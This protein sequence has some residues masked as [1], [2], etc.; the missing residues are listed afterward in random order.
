MCRIAGIVSKQSPE[1]AKQVVSSM[2][3][4]LQHGG[5]DD[6][7]VFQSGQVTLGHRRLSI[8]DLSPSGHQPM[9]YGQGDL[10]LSYNGEVYNYKELKAELVQ[11]GVTFKSSSD[12]EVILEAY[13]HW[14]VEAFGRFRGIF[15]FALL[16]LR[17]QKLLL[18]RDYPG[19]KPMY[20]WSV[21]D[22]ILFSSEVKAFCATAI[23][24]VEDIR[25]KQSFLAFGYLPHPITTIQGVT[26]L[27]PGCFLEIDIHTLESRRVSYLKPFAHRAFQSVEEGIHCVRESVEV[28]LKRNLVAD[29]PLGVFLSGGIDSSLLTL[30]C[31]KEIGESLVTVS[32]NFTDAAFDETPFQSRVIEKIGGRHHTSVTV[33]KGM[34]WKQMPAIWDAMDQ[35]T[36]DGVNSYFVSQAAHQAGLKAVLSGLGA[37][38]L[39]AGYQS[40]SR[41]QIIP[42]LRRLPAKRLAG[43]IARVVRHNWARLAYLTIEGPVGNALFL[44]GILTP[45]VIARIL[46]CDES[47][48]WNTLR[49]IPYERAPELDGAS[50]GMKLE[51]DFYMKNQLL[52]DTD[53]MSMR[54]ALEA[55]VPFLDA[56]V[57]SQAARLTP[58]YHQV[59]ADRPKYFLT[60]AFE[61]LLPAEIV[62]RKKQGFTFPFKPWLKEKIESDSSFLSQRSRQVLP[63]QSFREGRVH[64][65]QVWSGVVLEEFK[66]AR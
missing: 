63:V 49:G 31:A 55:R 11:L 22:E 7:G 16:D 38:E 50:E 14:G 13:R 34:L 42:M 52:K 32:V 53:V 51:Y 54:F 15:A 28:A 64:W 23:P 1:R 41:T 57:V 3:S 33:D 30:L 45:D 24:W 17:T 25:W 5:P 12:T 37:D 26:P 58:L 43:G 18:V 46:D 39:F 9:I 40:S 36:I 20:I 21:N 35:P 6:E 65:S 27:R 10:V 2:L 56:D 62:F 59:K 44:R 29:A 19:V 61:D 66:I 47:E 4:A 48:V 60:K 8:I